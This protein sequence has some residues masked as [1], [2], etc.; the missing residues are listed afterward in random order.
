MRMTKS[1]C[2]IRIEWEEF[3]MSSY[4]YVLALSV[5]ETIEKSNVWF[6]KKGGAEGLSKTWSSLQSEYS[7]LLSIIMIP[8]LIRMMASYSSTAYQ[9]E[10]TET[11]ALHP[12]MLFLIF[13]IVL[14][15]EIS[16][17]WLTMSIMVRGSNSV[18]SH[19]WRGGSLTDYSRVILLII[20]LLASFASVDNQVRDILTL[21]G[22]IFGAILIFCNLGSRA[23]KKLDIG[24]I[25]S[26][27][28]FSSLLVFL[29]A[30]L[31]GI[32][33]PFVALRSVHGGTDGQDAATD[34]EK[35]TSNP[36]GKRARQNITGAATTVAFV[37]LFSDVTS[38]QNS[39]GFNF[40]QNR[41]YVNL[42]IVIWWFLST[43]TSMSLCHRLDSSQSKKIE[44]FL[45]R[46]ETSPVGWIMPSVPNIVID[47]NLARGK[48]ILSRLSYG[49]DIICALLITFIASLITWMSLRELQ[50]EQVDSFWD[51]S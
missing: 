36:N 28:I 46:E 49:S 42:I 44:P 24:F 19:V 34:V 8:F 3:L 29:A 26:T 18:G 1:V 12:M 33:F 13:G 10:D 32:I 20:L 14:Q 5:V 51:W 41:P 27:N 6:R 22:T 37:F 38:I 11:T 47:P 30:L 39:L 2:F 45:R 21:I 17:S 35:I 7:G 31:S 4:R 16:H 9:D 40:A 15:N 25:D 43:L 48:M 50:G 23:W